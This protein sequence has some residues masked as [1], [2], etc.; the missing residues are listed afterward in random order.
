MDRRV[1]HLITG[2]GKGGAE[3]MLYQMLKYRTDQEI[4]H[5]V[6]SLGGAHYYEG[7][8]RELGIPVTELNFRTRPISGFLRLVKLL[9][10]TDTLCCWMYHANFVGYLA[11]KLVKIPRVIWCIRHSSLDPK[12][13]KKRSLFLNR[14]CACWSSRVTAVA[15]NGERSRLAHEAIGYAP[16]KGCVLSNGCDCEEYAPDDA[17]REDL[18][19]EL[20]IGLE[21]RVILSIT[22]YTPIKDVP[23][24]IRAF[25]ELRRKGADVAAVLCGV[26]VE[27]ENRELTALCAEE[28]L[29]IGR[30]VFL[31]GLRHDVPRLLAACDLYV[32]HSA[33]EAFPNALA[34]AMSCGCLCVATDVGDVKRILPD[35]YCIVQPGNA[36]IL[37]K[38]IIEFLELPSE[39][40]RRIRDQNRRTI[41]EKFDIH[42]IVQEYEALF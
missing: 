36:G 17:A 27:P 18:R 24:F 4:T 34:Q 29:E 9:R 30:D 22:K 42:K 6:V 38:K 19:R 32:L 39:G 33:G 1:T 26:G 31:L 21:T 10:G 25:G 3:T 28:R 8:I 14:V 12:L 37:A 15:Y 11:A 16:E 23:T 7:P 40:V 41:Q 20:R 5:Q 13:N 2:L 35:N